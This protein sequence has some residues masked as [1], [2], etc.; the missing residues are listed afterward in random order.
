M[1]ISIFIPFRDPPPNIP[2]NHTGNIQQ[3]CHTHIKKGYPNHPKYSFFIDLPNSNKFFFLLIEGFT[4]IYTIPMSYTKTFIC[5]TDNF[6]FTIYFTYPSVNSFSLLA[7]NKTP[8]I[9]K[10]ILE[11][12]FKV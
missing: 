3:F 4:D 12:K 8:I 7:K 10:I 1:N 5:E 6:I 11:K 2:F 9:K